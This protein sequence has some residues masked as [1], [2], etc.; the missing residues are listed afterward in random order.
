M[1]DMVQLG[2]FYTMKTITWD[3]TIIYIY[4]YVCVCANFNT[5][6]MIGPESSKIPV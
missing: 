5:S 1:G 3:D 6:T 2:G 4:M